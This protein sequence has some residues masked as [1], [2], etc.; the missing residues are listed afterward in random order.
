VIDFK[1]TKQTAL[2]VFTF[3]VL[4]SRVEKGG[5]IRIGNLLGSGN[6]VDETLDWRRKKDGTW[7]VRYRR[8]KA[9]KEFSIGDFVL[10]GFH[11][12]TTYRIE[13]VDKAQKARCLRLR[14][15]PGLGG[16]CM[17]PDA[18]RLLY[19][20]PP[21]YVIPFLMSYFRDRNPR[22]SLVT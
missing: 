13:S 11:W 10:A 14:E 9:V 8:N 16:Y 17:Q 3:K 2:D 1:P 19:V 5:G 6:V 15:I 4:Q 7:E 21:G 18:N 20:G 22:V 12:K